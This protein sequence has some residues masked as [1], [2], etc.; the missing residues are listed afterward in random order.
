[1]VF[2]D[3]QFEQLNLKYYVHIRLV[4]ALYDVCVNDNQWLMTHD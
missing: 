1:M 3:S 4:T 2:K